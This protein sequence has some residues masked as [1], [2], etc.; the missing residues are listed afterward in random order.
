MGV[1]TKSRLLPRL[2]RANRACVLTFAMGS[3][4]CLAADKGSVEINSVPPGAQIEINGVYLADTPFTWKIGRWAL[5]QPKYIFSKYLNESITMRISKAGFVTKEILITRGPLTWSSLNGQNHFTYYVIY[6]T[7]FNFILDTIGDFVGQNPFQKLAAIPA[8]TPVAPA[9]TLA[10]PEKPVEEIVKASLPAVVQIRSTAGL[11]SGFIISSSGLIVTNRH[12]VEGSG[13][14]SVTTSRGETITSSSIFVDQGRDL[15]IIRLPGGQYSYLPIAR[16]DLM[17]IGQEV[18]A[19]GSPLGFQNTVTRGVLSAFRKTDAVVYLQTDASINPGNSGGPLLNRQ[20]EVVGVNTLKITGGGVSGLDF[21]I[22]C[23]DLI[24]LLSQQF[25]L[26]PPQSNIPEGPTAGGPV[27]GIATLTNADIINLK[28]VGLGD[29]LIIEK[30]STSPTAFK[31]DA[32]DLV[33]LHQTGISDPVI[34]AMVHA[35]VK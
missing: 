7:P 35:L 2:A 24:A 19:I 17:S 13:E 34:R 3:V 29:E 14:V 12:V 32:S 16:P 25:N 5:H 33:E 30:I 28:K 11:G 31:L 22:S 1:R 4:L 23:G 21:A 26:A 9:A 8:N 20:G 15:A 18:I 6:P 27:S 10:P